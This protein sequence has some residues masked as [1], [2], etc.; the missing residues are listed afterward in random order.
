[1]T[2]TVYREKNNIVLLMLEKLVLNT[3]RNVCVCVR[4]RARA[5]VRACTAYNNHLGVDNTYC[6]DA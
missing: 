4:A 3:K 5:R 1:M 2:V 6:F